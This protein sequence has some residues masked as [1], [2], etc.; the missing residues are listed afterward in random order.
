MSRL[1][2][3]SVALSVQKV[4]AESQPARPDPFGLRKQLEESIKKTGDVSSDTHKLVQN[5]LRKSAEA[6]KGTISNV[7]H[8]DDGSST[9]HVRHT[10]PQTDSVVKMI[11]G[12]RSAHGHDANHAP[13]EALNISTSA[14]G[15]PTIQTKTSPL[16][17]GWYHTELHV[18]PV[19]SKLKEEEEVLDEAGPRK[20]P[21]GM[22]D[23][24]YARHEFG[25]DPEPTLKVGARVH[26]SQGSQGGK[27]TVKDLYKRKIVTGATKQFMHVKHDDGS[28]H[29]YRVDSTN[30]RLLKEDEVLDEGMDLT[31]GAEYVPQDKLPRHVKKA[32]KGVHAILKKH[33]I[34]DAR[35]S[36]TH[37]NYKP[38]NDN[39]SAGHHEVNVELGHRH[40]DNDKLVDALNNSQP[41]KWV[42]RKGDVTVAPAAS[43][44][45]S[46]THTIHESLEIDEDPILDSEQ[47]DLPSGLDEEFNTHDQASNRKEYLDKKHPRTMHEVVQGRRSGKYFVVR[48]NQH[49]A[50]VAEAVCFPDLES[51]GATQTMKTSDDPTK[52]IGEDTK[53]RRVNKIKSIIHSS[54]E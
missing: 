28:E 43:I 1:I 53:V 11:K 46:P 26:I 17:G 23:A 33:G 25:R 47:D 6:L 50:H 15:T 52:A 30:H 12:W 13:G 51:G 18:K 7:D 27:G 38:L 4:I 45:P 42:H 34:A 40:I 10:K 9:V 21:N 39:H 48:R 24:E 3:E 35:V 20:P 16:S 19:K 29:H 49:G 41:H 8:H 32:V 31:E 44:Y 2:P 36:V 14:S 37:H 5:S 54:K 22:S